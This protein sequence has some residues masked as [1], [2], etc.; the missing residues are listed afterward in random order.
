MIEK[1]GNFW[2]IQLCPAFEEKKARESANIPS[3]AT[4]I[5]RY[6]RENGEIVYIGR[7]EIKNRLASPERNDW[8]FD[9]IEYSIVNDPDKQ[10]EWEDYWINKFKEENS[11]KL[12]LYNK[13]ASSSKYSN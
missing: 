8:E 4:G 2:V 5:Y 10:V 12:P 1:E 9:V 11:G 3:D 7:G 6:V 13:I